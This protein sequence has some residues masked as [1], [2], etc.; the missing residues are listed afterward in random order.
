MYHASMYHVPNVLEVMRKSELD[1]TGP[2][3]YVNM[4]VSAGLQSAGKVGI[5]YEGRPINKLQN[6]IILLIFKI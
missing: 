6:S 4:H 1:H 3:T 2:A 5:K